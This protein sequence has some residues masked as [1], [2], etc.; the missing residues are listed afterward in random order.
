[1]LQNNNDILYFIYSNQISNSNKIN[2]LI[3][4]NT[5]CNCTKCD[6]THLLK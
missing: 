3:N 6:Y 4:D 1:M 2:I 5:S